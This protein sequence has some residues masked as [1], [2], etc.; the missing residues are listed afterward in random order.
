[1]AVWL[2]QRF[3]GGSALLRDYL[4][5][6][7]SSGACGVSGS[8]GIVGGGRYRSGLCRRGK[9]H[10]KPQ[11]HITPGCRLRSLRSLRPTLVRSCRLL[12][13]RGANGLPLRRVRQP[14]TLGASVWVTF[15]RTALSF[16]VEVHTYR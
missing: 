7:G 8:D 5:P 13:S 16:L 4:R 3:S 14:E 1:M 15:Y 10:R 6:W 2:F 11:L 9:A 12:K